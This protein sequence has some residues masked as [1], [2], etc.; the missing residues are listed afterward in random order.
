VIL[1]Q[2]IAELAEE[3]FNKQETLNAHM[4]MNTPTAFDDRKAAFIKMEEARAAAV[5]ARRA[6]DDASGELSAS[7]SKCVD[8]DK[9]S[10]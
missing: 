8:N 5:K 1:S 6:L 3:V 7:K 2:T 10:G 9:K 4:A